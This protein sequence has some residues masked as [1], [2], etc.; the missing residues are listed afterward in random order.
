MR[1]LSRAFGLVYDPFQDD[2]S[3]LISTLRESEAVRVIKPAK[4]REIRLCAPASGRSWPSAYLSFR[5]PVSLPLE[6][7]N[8]ARLAPVFE[9]PSVVSLDDL[10]GGVGVVAIDA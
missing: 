3:V 7:T 4:L 2:A 10:V 9:V 6:R 1:M 5:K 8:L